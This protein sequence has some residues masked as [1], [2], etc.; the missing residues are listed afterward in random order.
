MRTKIAR[1]TAAGAVLRFFECTLY[2]KKF[3]KVLENIQRELNLVK[4]RNISV[5]ITEIVFYWNYPKTV[6]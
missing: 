2:K 4:S 1:F 5:L 3:V 6:Y